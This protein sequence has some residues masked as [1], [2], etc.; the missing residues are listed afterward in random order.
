METLY[1]IAVA[2]ATV[3]VGVTI[4]LRQKSGG[5]ARVEVVRVYLTASGS[6]L[7]VRYCVRRA[8]RLPASDSEIYIMCADGK[9]VGEAA[10]V[11][12]IGRLAARSVDRKTGG[13][14]LLR[15][16]AKVKRGDK[17]SMIVGRDRQDGLEVF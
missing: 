16:T 9:R 13:Y 14:L 6:M 8:G 5:R 7:D 10:K 4:Y 3:I 11:V 1:L 15:N 2:L 12:K 17:V